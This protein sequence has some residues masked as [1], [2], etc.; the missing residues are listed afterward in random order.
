MRHDWMH[1]VDSDLFHAKS[2]ACSHDSLVTAT[3]LFRSVCH[4]FLPMTGLSHSRPQPIGRS[5]CLPPLRCDPSYTGSIPSRLREW[6]SI[7]N[8]NE[9]FWWESNVT[10]KNKAPTPNAGMFLLIPFGTVGQLGWSR[11]RCARTTDSK[12]LHFPSRSN[13]VSHAKEG[14]KWPPPFVGKVI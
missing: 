3:I 11:S 9:Q 14:I 2:G 5:L 13:S 6:S 12:A 10:T 8:R 4:L 7:Q 1:D